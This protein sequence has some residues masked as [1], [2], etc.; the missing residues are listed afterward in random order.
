MKNLFEKWLNRKVHIHLGGLKISVVIVDIKLSYGK[1]RF[2]VSPE[3]GTGEIWV[4]SFLEYDG[5]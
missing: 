3:S 5:K 4:E 2:Q 1:Y